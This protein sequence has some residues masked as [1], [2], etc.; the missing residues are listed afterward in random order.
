M[1]GNG[2]RPILDGYAGRLIALAVFIGC[3]AT[4]A[5]IYRDTLFPPAVEQAAE[6]NDPFFRCFADST[7]KIDKMV[8]DGLIS[9]AQA[10]LFRNRAEARCRAESDRAAGSTAGP[11][12]P[13]PK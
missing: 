2:G 5:Y 4:L 8:A 9:G 7:L 1:N 10:R 11:P 13:K 3:A 12:K 6:Q